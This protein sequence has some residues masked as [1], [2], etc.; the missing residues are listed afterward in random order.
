MAQIIIKE[1]V[2][3][4]D[5]EDFIK[6]HKEANFLH[7]WYWGRFHKNLGKTI[8]R[9]GCYKNGQLIG[10][11]LSIVEDAKRGKYLTVPGG[12]IIDWK[13]SSLIKAFATEIKRTAMLNDCAFVRV[14]QQLLSDGFSKNIFKKNGFINAPMHLHAELTNQLDIAKPE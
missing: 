11:V 5:W 1:T 2:E 4:K 7:S 8:K 9:T 13:N 12:P 14:R 10:V 3:K 6:K